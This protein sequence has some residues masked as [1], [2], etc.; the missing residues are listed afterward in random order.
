M[1]VPLPEELLLS[2]N[3][4]ISCREVQIEQLASLLSVCEPYTLQLLAALTE[5]SQNFPAR[6]LSVFMALKLQARA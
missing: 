4:S 6:L 1:D 3:Q 2:L 5:D